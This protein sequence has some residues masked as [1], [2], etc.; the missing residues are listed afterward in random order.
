[1]AAQSTK[2]LRFEFLADTKKFLGNVGKVG[3]KFSD[4]GTQMK[5][6]GDKINKVFAGIGVAA[7]AV[8]TKSLGA[9]R[10]FETGM[11]EVF[12]LLPGTTQ[13]AF[14]KINT[15]VLR[16]AK[17][18]G[19]LPEDIIPALY[20]SLSA[21]VPP[22]NV[23]AFL[24]TANKL[25]VGGAT[26]LGIA[27]D[28][29]TTVV[30]A[31]G[32]DVISVGEASDIIFTAVKGGKTTVEQLSKAM[33]N[34]API[35][36]SMG[37][38]FGNVTA[39]VATLTASGT[40]TS[41]AMTQIRAAL[42]ELAKPTSKVSKL[43]TELTGK[44]FE[45]FIASGGDMKEGFDLIK[46]GAEKNNKPLA[47]YVGSVEALGAIQTLTGKGSEKFASEIIAAANS[48]GATD[49]A[50]A[51]GSKGIGLVLEK[52]QAAFSVLQI[53]IGQKLA[54][55]LIEA[56]DKIQAKFK[57]I[58]P[59]LQAFVDNVK[60]FFASDVVRSTINK[61]TDAFKGLQKR[62]APVVDKI[63]EFFQANPKVAFT[64]LA[65]VIG[66]ILLASVISIA[67]AFAALFSP[68]TLI[69]GA[70]AGLAAGFRFAFDNV[71]VFRNFVTNSINFLKN[72]FTN[73]ISFFKGDGFV[74]SFNTGLNFVKEQFNNLKEVFSGVVK[75]ISGLFSGD[76]NLAV[77]GLK[78]IFNGLLN[79]FSSSWDLFGT[80]K[81]VFMNA[82][83]KTK[84]FLVPKLKEFG[85]NFVETIT[86]VI[87]TGA[88]VVMEG[89]KFVFNKV[90][91]KINGFIN[92]LNSGLGFSFFGIDINP[93]DLPNIPRLAKGGIVKE[94]T[95][96]MIG[97]AGTE[98]VIPLPS[99][100]GGG[101]GLGGDVYNLN[102]NAGLGTDGADVGRQIIEQI[103]KY[104]RRNLRIV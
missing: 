89:V 79:F 69:I 49:D 55:L 63:S 37:I 78:N 101:N 52:L 100:V 41:V 47:E 72:L 19:K 80:L 15:D 88:G 77:E 82:L 31:F 35:A 48:V 60:S 87:K 73:F 9:F 7:G 66:G 58:Q 46:A 75:F 76:V 71:E 42:S 6:S 99:G 43:F 102:I 92:D 95:L 70:I 27:V 20:D 25:A 32:S 86:T 39:A 96:A 8:A 51:Q 22:D 53:E 13:E 104:N 81:D 74:N 62:L 44:S 30:N 90:I 98:A 23:F 103:E 28:G 17:E 83:T 24:E 33:F 65:V 59:G 5:S 16:L 14:D 1:M 97:E 21:G 36:A 50:F 56:I 93:P 64:G 2:T 40:P 84:D 12:T 61:L 4:V 29:L 34:V 11:N 57:E 94:P 10:D 54:P 26:E 3:K 85:N 45:E 18:I 91:D 67:S 68:V 38:E